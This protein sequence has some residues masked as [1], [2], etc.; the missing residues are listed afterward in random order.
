MMKVT[1]HTGDVRMAMKGMLSR[2]PAEI[3]NAIPLGLGELHGVNRRFP[4]LHP[5]ANPVAG[6]AK[7]QARCFDYI[8][9]SLA[10]PVNVIFSN[11]DEVF[12]ARWGKEWAALCQQGT[13]DCVTVPDEENPIFRHFLQLYAHKEICRLIVGYDQTKR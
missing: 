4:L 12:T 8:T 13:F 5:Y 2:C 9:R 6:N 3:S 1:P 10:K 11:N 7:A